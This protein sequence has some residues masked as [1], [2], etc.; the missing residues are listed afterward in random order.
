MKSPNGLAMLLISDRQ[1]VQSMPSIVSLSTR[2]ANAWSVLPAPL[3]YHF[4]PSRTWLAFLP[5]ATGSA[6][7]GY[8]RAA[9]V[10]YHDRGL[11]ADPALPL[12]P[13]PAAAPS[14]SG[15]GKRR[16]SCFRT[17]EKPIL[18]SP[19]DESGAGVQ[20]CK[21]ERHGWWVDQGGSRSA[22]A[23]PVRVQTSARAAA[24]AS[25]PSARRPLHHLS[26]VANV[27]WLMSPSHRA[28][29]LAHAL[30]RSK[31]NGLGL[32]GP[33]QTRSTSCRPRPQRP[34]RQFLIWPNHGPE[35]LTETSSLR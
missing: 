29:E 33:Y 23:E 20:L 5:P 32:V 11:P 35:G 17:A 22:E 6:C 4:L 25:L 8:P 28:V 3:L 19:P 30:Q 14:R 9:A 34:R 27:R 12:P 1:R 10:L 21:G 24:W 26:G 13:W 7:G 18:T 31:L 2:V 15:R 16:A